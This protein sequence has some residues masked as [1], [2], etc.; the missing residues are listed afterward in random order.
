MRFHLFQN[1]FG[2]LTDGQVDALIEKIEAR[3]SSVH[4]LRGRLT[5]LQSYGGELTEE[6]DN[7]D[8]IVVQHVGVDELRK[9]YWWSRTVYVVEAA[10][11]DICINSGKYKENL[12]R[13]ERRGMGG[14]SVGAM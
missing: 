13:P 14:Q 4:L 12:P 9:R 7:A 10:F 5:P 1:G 11:V 2:A 6:A 3:R 8:A